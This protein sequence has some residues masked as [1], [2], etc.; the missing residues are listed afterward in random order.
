MSR[1]RSP[2]I[3]DIELSEP[4]AEDVGP[5]PDATIGD[6]LHRFLPFLDDGA[7]IDPDTPLADY[8]LD[9]L[10]LISLMLELE[11]ALDIVFPD[12]ELNPA[13]FATARILRETIDRLPEAG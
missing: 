6:V 3:G 2:E 13:A 9:S 8:G 7:P 4:A 11:D 12:D 5:D 10:A 1:P